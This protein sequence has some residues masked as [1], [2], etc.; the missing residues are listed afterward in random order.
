M[1][2]LS[3]IYVFNLVLV[4]MFFS[5][6]TPLYAELEQ[7]NIILKMNRDIEEW[8]LNLLASVQLDPKSKLIE[9]ETDGCSGGLSDAWNGFAKISPEFK[10]HFNER[11]PWES[12]CVTHD[13]AYWKGD[14]E[15]GFNQRLQA[16]IIL[17]QCVLNYGTENSNRLAKKFN[18]SEEKILTQIKLTSTL[19]YHA[20][21]L[22]GKPCSYLPWRWGYG[23]P[24]CELL[25]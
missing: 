18:V 7:E 4:I 24:H 9:F 10:E 16:D 11:P 3:K 14:T 6:L 12:C 5:I 15:D 8:N 20:V 19:M 22:G 25:K 2:G 21:R 23:W 17:R 1:K 13:R